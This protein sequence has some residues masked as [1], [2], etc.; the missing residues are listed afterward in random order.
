VQVAAGDGGRG[1][2]PGVTSSF[3][4]HWSGRTKV[5]LRP[6]AGPKARLGLG[7]HAADDR[8]GARN[9]WCAG[10]VVIRPSQAS[11]T[12]LSLREVIPAQ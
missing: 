8:F 11:I 6:V 12:T 10:I 3:F 7:G 2:S 4:S 9:T 1:L 5:T